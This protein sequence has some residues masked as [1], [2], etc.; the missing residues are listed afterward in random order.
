MLLNKVKETIQRHNLFLREEKILIAFSG[1]IDSTALLH[2]LRELQEEWPITLALGHFNH[3]LRQNAE[4]EELFVR[5]V[6]E[7]LALPLYVSSKDV[8]AYAVEHKLNIEE[9]G[10]KLRYDFLKDTAKKNGFSKIATGHTKNDQAE[11][12]FIRLFRGSGLTG[13]SGIFPVVD[14]LI[15]RPLLYTKREEIAAYLKHINAEFQVD[16]SNLDRRFLR[17]RIRSELL[18][19]ILKEFD[20]HLISKI[21]KVSSLFQEDE[22]VLK[23]LAD[24]ELPKAVQRREGQIFLDMKVLST[25]PVG[26]ARRVTREFIAEIKGDLRRISFES[27]VSVLDLAEGKEYSLTKN[28]FLRREQDRIF[29]PQADLETLSYELL[30]TGKNS[31]VIKDLG[32][33]FFGMEMARLPED[34][35]FDNFK[36]V[37]LDLEKLKFPLTIR[38][39]RE[40]DRYQPLGSPGRK[41]IKEIMRAKKIPVRERNRRPVFL[42]AGEIVWIYGLPV[43]DKFK[44]VPETKDVF[45]IS[46]EKKSS[47]C[48]FL[49]PHHK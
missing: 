11:T 13:L 43:A 37:Y 28:C 34:W 38:S 48:S 14:D 18:P 26:L 35:E 7:K 40:G 49:E 33:C 10:R 20:P 16:E 23:K 25:F 15:I 19:Y 45:C 27:I 24:K 31:L 2:L 29:C 41:K 32:M 12:F 44:I 6:A 30:W 5:N 3:K 39:R 9:A 21:G 42:S 46:L 4:K 47:P 8:R 1:G 17:N 36:A 22:F